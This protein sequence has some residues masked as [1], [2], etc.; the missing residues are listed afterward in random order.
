MVFPGT[1]RGPLSPSL[2]GLSHAC[3]ASMPR[4]TPRDPLFVS[5]GLRVQPS[6]P[7]CAL[8]MA[9]TAVGWDRSQGSPRLLPVP[10]EMQVFHV[11]LA[12]PGGPGQKAT[13]STLRCLPWTWRS[14]SLSPLVSVYCLHLSPPASSLSLPCPYLSLF[15]TLRALSRSLL[16]ASL[17]P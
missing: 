12:H 5:C 13:S 8:Q 3:V 2:V 11:C 1:L 7:L 4:N 15:A 9:P 16:S 6:L 10:Q 14:L 17:S